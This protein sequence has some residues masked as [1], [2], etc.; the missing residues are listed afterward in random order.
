MITT[1][2]SLRDLRRKIYAKVK[3]ER[4]GAFGVTWNRQSF[5]WERWS[6]H[7]LRKVLSAG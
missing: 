6:T 5:G 1:P 2:I 7:D 3:A 4:V